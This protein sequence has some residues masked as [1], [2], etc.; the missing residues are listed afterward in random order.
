MTQ[1]LTSLLID[2]SCDEIQLQVRGCE[3]Q[4]FPLQEWQSYDGTM[5]A[6]MSASGALTVTGTGS[7]VQTLT[8][9]ASGANPGN[10]IL[11]GSNA[12]EGAQIDLGGATGFVN[13]YIDRYDNLMRIFRSDATAGGSTVQ[14]LN[15]GAG[16]KI[17]IYL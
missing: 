11:K 14:F 9:N 17:G 5:L 7:F 15:F 1:Q 2:G 6:R 10:L 4:S 13:M 8:V 16:G 12:N 3:G